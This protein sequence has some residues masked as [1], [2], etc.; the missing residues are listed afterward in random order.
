MKYI[1][2]ILVTIGFGILYC[3]LGVVGNQFLPE[4]VAWYSPTSVLSGFLAIII[5]CAIFVTSLGIYTN[6]KQK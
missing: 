1:I 3:F 6:I 5:A 4:H 2:T